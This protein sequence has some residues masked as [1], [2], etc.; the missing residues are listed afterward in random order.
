[1]SD[2]QSE[3]RDS[4]DRVAAGYAEHFRDEL[5]RKPFDR[6]MLD[7]LAE[8]VAGRGTIC[9][10]GCGPGQVAAYLA[11]RGLEVCGV[12]LSPG[13]VHEARRLHPDVP[14][15]VGDMLALSSVADA[16]YGGVAAF[17]SILHLP[18]ERV[19]EALRELHRVLRPGGVL[20]VAFHLGRGALHRDEFLGRPVALDFQLFETAEMREYLAAAGLRVEEAVERDPYPEVE[21]Q[22]RRAYVF[23]RK[24]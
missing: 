6:L 20:L 9:D 7:W 19:V 4:Y 15:A 8:K 16:S 21:Y 14:F 2:A 17:Y 10:M 23:A 3:L 11:G 5:A 24:P 1:M 18:R 12:D 22:S 13:M